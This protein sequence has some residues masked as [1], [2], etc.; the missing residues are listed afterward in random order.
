MRA[1]ILLEPRILLVRSVLVQNMLELNFLRVRSMLE[2]K[3]LLVPKVPRMS[4]RLHW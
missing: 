1:P 2:Q 4:L 3:I